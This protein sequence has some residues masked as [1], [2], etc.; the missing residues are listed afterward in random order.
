MKTF[1]TFEEKYTA[2]IDGKLSGKELENFERELA[3]NA[4]IENARSD[5]LSANRLRSLL[6][7]NLR[8][9]ALSNADFFNHQLMQ[10]IESEQK[11]QN[12][13]SP[14]AEEN[15]RQSRVAAFFWTLPRMAWAG[16]FCL[17]L[18][19]ALY[20]AAV[21]KTQQQLAENQEYVAKILS[22]HTDDPNISATTFHSKEN[23]ATVL[24]LDGLDYIP[25]NYKLK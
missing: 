14:E 4:P 6:R 20:L 10:Q 13:R 19:A 9:P 22:A 24:W 16:A 15:S 17:I 3:A 8:A 2:W 18:A 25:E 23:N 1:E 7:E 5:K 12:D 21:P 11:Q